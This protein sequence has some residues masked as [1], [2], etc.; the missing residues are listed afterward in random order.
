MIEQRAEKRSIS[1]NKRLFAEADRLASK[2]HFTTFSEYVRSLII[3]DINGEF[4]L[5]TK[6]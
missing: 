2:R 6:R 4:E 3:R 1:G 5:S